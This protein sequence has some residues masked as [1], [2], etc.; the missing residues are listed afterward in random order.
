MT[1]KKVRLKALWEQ[2]RWLSYL[3]IKDEPYTYGF[4]RRI[5]TR[6]E[7]L[8]FLRFDSH[9]REPPVDNP[10]YQ[11]KTASVVADTA[12]G[13]DNLK[14][15]GGGWL[16]RPDE[17][18]ELYFEDGGRYWPGGLEIMEDYLRRVCG[19]GPLRRIFGDEAV[20]RWLRAFLRL[21]WGA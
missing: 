18:E 7:R 10:I 13:A 11:G 2:D 5:P 6:E 21:P 8:E 1:C 3:P 20:A 4:V 19:I 16:P 12:K 15:Y 14:P 9:G 17:L